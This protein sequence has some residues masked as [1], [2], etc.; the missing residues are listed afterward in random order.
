MCQLVRH[1]AALLLSLPV[2][3]PCRPR[4]L[5]V[6]GRPGVG[7][8]CL[9]RDMCRLMSSSPN[10]GGLGLHV[11][12]LDTTGRLAGG[13][14]AGSK[15]LVCVLSSALLRTSHMTPCLILF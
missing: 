14:Q 5:L 12:M 1:P 13:G 2:A 15:P 6:L 7:K 11:M 8:S 9:L 10:E 3:V 4:S